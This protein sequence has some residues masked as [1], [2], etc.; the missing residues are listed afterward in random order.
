MFEIVTF[1]MLCEHLTAQFDE[2]KIHTD[3]FENENTNKIM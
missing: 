2:I 3:N 1:K